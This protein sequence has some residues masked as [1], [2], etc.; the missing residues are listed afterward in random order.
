[1]RLFIDIDGVRHVN[2]SRG[3][4]AGDALLRVVASRIARAVRTSDTVARYGRNEFLV[5]CEELRTAGETDQ[6]V[7]RIREVADGRDA[8]LGVEVAVGVGIA[9]DP[10][11]APVRLLGVADEARYRAKRAA[12]DSSSGDPQSASAASPPTL[13]QSSP[14]DLRNW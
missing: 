7:T 12:R 11:I 1:M 13:G 3:R 6:I 2:E 10:K 4:A 9:T 8:H 14:T 5:L